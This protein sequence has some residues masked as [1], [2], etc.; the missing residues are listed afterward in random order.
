MNYKES[1]EKYEQLQGHKALQLRAVLFDMDGVLFDSMPFHADAWSQVMTEAG[2]NFSR[3]D[4][5][6]NEGRTGADTINT[7][8]I[9]QFGHP[10]TPEQ[11]EALC[12]AK[13]DIFATYPPTPRMPGA[14]ELIGKVK[15]CGLTPMIVTGSGTPTLLDRIQSNFPGLF[16]ENHIVTSFN[17]KRGKPYPDPYLLALEKGG[18]APNEAIVVENA[19]LG[20]TAGVAAGLF[21]IAANTGPLKDSVLSDAGASLVFPS[22]QALCDEWD[23]LYA[24]LS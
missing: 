3:E 5:Y 20:V 14:L 8:S 7:A 1:I 2:F 13:C 12:K 24:A 15:A 9:A 16:D 23:N 17:V 4:V 10:S 21:T 19:P 18:F 11:I 22:I 6:M